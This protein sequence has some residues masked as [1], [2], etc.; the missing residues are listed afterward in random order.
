[1]VE[2]FQ[3]TS[4]QLGGSFVSNLAGFRQA[5]GQIG[6]FFG[7]KRAE[8]AAAEGALPQFD[9]EGKPIL[10]EQR[11]TFRASNRAF[12]QSS[13]KAYG[14]SVQNDVTENISRIK[15]ENS[16][17]PQAF[18]KAIDG[19]K[20]GLLG[21]VADPIKPSVIQLF[22]RLETR[23]RI[24]VNAD[25]RTRTNEEN[26]A[27]IDQAQTGFTDEAM[28]SIFNGDIVAFET[29][30]ESFVSSLD[31]PL[32]SPG[33][34]LDR[35]Q[36]FDDTADESQFLGAID[37]RYDEDPRLALKALSDFQNTNPENLD[38]SPQRQ[39]ELVAKGFSSV[40][41]RTKLS[42]QIETIGDDEV[43]RSQKAAEADLTAKAYSSTLS[44]AE[45]IDAV[46]KRLITPSAAD[47][48]R[49][50]MNNVVTI[51]DDP[52]FV[53]NFERD[54][55][56]LITSEAEAQLDAG[57]ANGQLTAS[58]AGRLQRALATRD[59]TE[60]D[61]L[62]KINRDLLKGFVT[63][64]GF[65]SKFDPQKEKRAAASMADYNIRVAAGEN[66]NEVLLDIIDNGSRNNEIVLR[67]LPQL[68]FGSVDNLDQAETDVLQANERGEIDEIQAERE[69]ELIRDMRVLKASIK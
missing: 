40:L 4:F 26:R 59:Q 6:A 62:I 44:N 13:L 10:P 51:K 32:F 36:A 12:N 53:L 65:L 66:P 30:R 29:A 1:M 68:R 22:D 28:S 23:A 50:R 8:K 27:L 24:G 69:L 20:V 18:Q 39:A 14:A 64:Q 15:T 9:E 16:T 52:N 35:I 61:D 43:E 21:E 34:V 56:D 5:T 55:P 45:L 57:V 19:Y 3:P 33:E 60:E 37:Q 25:F 2:R 46:N 31:N 47:R 38:M 67:T 17:D 48:L 58:T 42:E 7:Q 63:E 54:L 41:N 49:K 11:G